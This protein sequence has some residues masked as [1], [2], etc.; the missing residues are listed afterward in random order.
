MQKPQDRHKD[1]GHQRDA[2]HKVI[3]NR[4]DAELSIAGFDNAGNAVSPAQADH[5]V[6]AVK[7]ADGD[8]AHRAK[9][10]WAKGMAKLPMLQPEALSMANAWRSLPWGDT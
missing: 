3:Q 6:A 9:E 1:I 5:A 8:N 7:Q 4:L 10:A 2:V